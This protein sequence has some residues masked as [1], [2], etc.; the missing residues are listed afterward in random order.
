MYEA[1]TV[2]RM[3]Q[4]HVTFTG[5]RGVCHRVLWHASNE[6]LQAS[7]QLAHGAERSY[8]LDAGE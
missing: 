7:V 8:A 3:N 2:V 1:R 4:A 6:M 5:A